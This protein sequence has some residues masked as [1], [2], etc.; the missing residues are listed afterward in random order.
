M[1]EKISGKL[2]VQEAFENNLFNNIDLW[3][4]GRIEVI[5][6]YQNSPEQ[7]WKPFW[8]VKDRQNEVYLSIFDKENTFD[9]K[10][11]QQKLDADALIF[12]QQKVYILKKTEDDW[13]ILPPFAILHPE[14]LWQLNTISDS[15]YSCSLKQAFDAR[16]NYQGYYWKTNGSYIP[17]SPAEQQ[18]ITKEDLNYWRFETVNFGETVFL[19]DCEF[20]VWKYPQGNIYLQRLRDNYGPVAVHNVV[21]Q[22][23]YI[24]ADKKS[25]FVDIDIDKS[26]TKYYQIT[27]MEAFLYYITA[28]YGMELPRDKTYFTPRQIIEAVEA[29]LNNRIFV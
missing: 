19:R 13:Q 6:V 21:E 28:H 8:H 27:S 14:W 26:L 7:P 24:Y 12:W 18:P 25:A 9:K 16:N 22:A 20:Y 4:Y 10:A 3:L 23:I 15:D 17:V 2:A 5:S 11:P 1:I 29:E